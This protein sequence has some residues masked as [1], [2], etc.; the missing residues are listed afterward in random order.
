MNNS[1][2][3]ESKRHIPPDREPSMYSKVLRGIFKSQQAIEDSILSTKGAIN[4]FQNKLFSSNGTLD[5]HDNLE[6]NST[7]ETNGTTKNNNKTTTVEAHM[8][9]KDKINTIK[10]YQFCIDKYGEL[11]NQCID[12]HEDLRLIFMN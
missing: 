10:Q 7:L 2:E 11:D 6:T 1:N 3:K 4:T 8:S 12:L 9:V 5:T